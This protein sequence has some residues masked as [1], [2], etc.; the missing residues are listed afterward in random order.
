[1]FSVNDYAGSQGRI[2]LN[3]LKIRELGFVSW[4]FMFGPGGGGRTALWHF[5]VSS[6]FL[7]TTCLD[8]ISHLHRNCK[9]STRISHT[10]VIQILHYYLLSRLL[11]FSVLFL[12][13]HFKIVE[14]PWPFILKYPDVVSEIRAF[15]NWA[16]AQLPNQEM[17]VCYY[18]LCYWQPTSHF[19]AD[20]D[21]RP[22]DFF[23][24]PEPSLG[25]AGLYNLL[26]V[27]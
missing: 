18:G 17:Q 13:N 4:F 9:N 6:F 12:L 10:S 16:A 25:H 19:T 2:S 27:E 1:M 22:R 26:N 8:A 15:S 21:T 11:L 3:K 14:I 23:L 5:A 24:S 7:V 20:S